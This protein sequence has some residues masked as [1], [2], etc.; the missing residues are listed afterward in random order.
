MEISDISRPDP[1]KFCN[2]CW[3]GGNINT[4]AGAK[5]FI[6]GNLLGAILGN[7]FNR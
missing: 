2:I 3:G 5:Q 1:L 4:D 7:A 6:L